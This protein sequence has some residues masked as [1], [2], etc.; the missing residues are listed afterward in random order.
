MSLTAIVL[1]HN[2][3]KTIEKCLASLS[4][5]SEILVVDNESTDKTITLAQN[6]THKIVTHPLQ[7]DF[8]AQ[9]NWAMKNATND[10]ILFIDSDEVVTPEL[11]TEIQKVFSSSTP[12]VSC[13]KIKRIDIFMGQQVAHGE[14]SNAAT[15]IIRLMKRETGTWKGTVH[16]TWLPLPGSVGQ[17]DN[18]I[19]HFAHASVSDFIR[20]VNFYSTLRAKE[21]LSAKKKI[22]WYDLLTYPFGKFLYTYFWKMGFLDGAPGFIYS[23]LMSFHS[24]LVRAKLFQ[25][26]LDAKPIPAAYNK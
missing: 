5:C 6:F 4:F 26:Y 2:S 1:T 10:W 11:A 22:S 17:L 18:A 9:R 19:H 23:F 15:G 13:Y 24:F 3:E 12:V 20:K 8:S 14:V 21:L 7:N 25:Y 16:E